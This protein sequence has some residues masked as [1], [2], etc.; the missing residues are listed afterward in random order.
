MS[1][2]VPVFNV[3][4]ISFEPCAVFK[5]PWGCDCYCPMSCVFGWGAPDWGAACGS[6]PSQLSS[7]MG[8]RVCSRVCPGCCGA[9]G[10]CCPCNC[11]PFPWLYQAL[12]DR[13]LLCLPRSYLHAHPINT[14]H[15]SHCSTNDSAFQMTTIVYLKLYIEGIILYRF[16][17]NQ[18]SSF[19]FLYFTWTM[20]FLRTYL[21]YCIYFQR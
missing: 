8:V 5:S 9:E 4:L 16:W 21:C 15:F 2:T 20:Y 17:L 7:L 3:I 13:L 6:S 12:S 18:K 10:G 11:S 14:L 1:S 19:F